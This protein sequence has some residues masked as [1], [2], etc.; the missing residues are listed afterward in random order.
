M[1]CSRFGGA[2]VAEVHILKRCRGQKSVSCCKQH[3]FLI[4]A[5][6]SGVGNVFQQPVFSLG[7]R[8]WWEER[9]EKEEMEGSPELLL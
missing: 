2:I 7:R 4:Q 5:Q 6:H 9:A 1:I 3:E 8:R